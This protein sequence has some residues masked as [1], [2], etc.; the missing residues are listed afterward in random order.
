MVWHAHHEGTIPPGFN[1]GVHRRRGLAKDWEN[2]N[3]KAL[4]FRRLASL[5]LTLR[6]LCN[7]S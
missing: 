4:A 2:P 1:P 3:L 5:R 6:K 7:P